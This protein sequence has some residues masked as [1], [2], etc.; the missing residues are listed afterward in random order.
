M[1][2]KAGEGQGRVSKQHCWSARCSPTAA[3]TGVE[4]RMPPALIT[5]QSALGSHGIYSKSMLN[6]LFTWDIGGSIA[7]H[8]LPLD[9]NPTFSF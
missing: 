1:G 7:S 3:D 5:Y 4:E 9:T 8:L 6:V 2:V